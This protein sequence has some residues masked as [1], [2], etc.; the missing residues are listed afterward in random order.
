MQVTSRF[1]IAIQTMLE[2][3]KNEMDQQM[4]QTTLK[5]LLEDTKSY[6]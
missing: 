4:K 3:I 5:Q 2:K 6:L 1:T